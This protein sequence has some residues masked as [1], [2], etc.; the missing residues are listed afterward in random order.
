MKAAVFHAP[1]R[2]LTIEEIAVERPRCEMLVR[3]AAAG[4]C[5]SDLH[6]IEGTALKTRGI[7]RNLVVFEH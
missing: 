7:A 6:F 4:R 5:H 1:R 3:T 2:P